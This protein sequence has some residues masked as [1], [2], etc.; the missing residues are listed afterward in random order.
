MKKHIAVVGAGYAGLTAAYHLSNFGYQV[1]VYESARILGGRARRAVINQQV[2]DN[3]QHILSGAYHSLL[4]LYDAVDS[5]PPHLHKLTLDWWMWN[6]FR[7]T[8]KPNFGPLSPLVGICRAKGITFPEKLKFLSFLMGLQFGKKPKSGLTVAAW[9]STQPAKIIRYFWEPLCVAALNTPIFKAD[10]QVFYHVLRDGLIKA[11]LKEA[12][13]LPSVDLTALLPDRMANT[14]AEQNGRILTSRRVKAIYE[15]AKKFVV[16]DAQGRSEFDGIVLAIAP[17]QMKY[18]DIQLENNQSLDEYRSYLNQLT[19]ES[20]TTVYLQYPSDCRLPIAMVGIHGCTE[21]AL[22]QWAFDRG[23]ITNQAG[24]IAVVVSTGDTV[25]QLPDEVLQAKVQSEITQYFFPKQH[26]LWIKTVREKRA[27]ISC[28][29]HK[30]QSTSNVV[31]L[32]NSFYVAGDY[33][34]PLYP[35][36]LESA[37]Q[38]GEQ[39]AQLMHKYLLT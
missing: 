7:L 22:G 11:P 35:A 27:T 31:S 33:L 18:I 17:Y 6:R 21:N 10:A 2:L 39:A 32:T 26:P 13:I 9:V 1:T 37:C 12:L 16:D 23:Q 8:I 15:S 34:H 30:V 38:S 29:V 36:T 4:K 3:G 28:D 25:D 5:N 14:I 19:Y 20:I 24:L